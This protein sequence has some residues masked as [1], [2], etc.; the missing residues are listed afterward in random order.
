MTFQI[1]LLL[2]LSSVVLQLAAVVLI[3][4]LIPSTGNAKAWLVL[5]AAFVAMAAHLIIELLEHIGMIQGG[6]WL[7]NLGDVLTL[8]VS[9]FLVLGIWMTRK[10][11]FEYTRSKEQLCELE[12]RFYKITQS[13]QDA[14]IMMGADKKISFWNDAAERMFGYSATEALGHDMHTL[15]APAQV[16]TAFERGFD[17]F[18]ESGEGPV[19]GKV[20]EVV[21]VRKGGTEFP[22]ELSISATKVGGEWN[23]IGIVRDITER[24][25]AEDALKKNVALLSEMGKMAKVGGWEL[26]VETGELAWTEEV[27]DIHEVDMATYKPT[28]SEAV[29]FYAPASR[30]VIERL[31]DRAIKY[32]EPFDAELELITAKGNHRWV[33]A[34]GSVYQQQDKVKTVS[35]TFHDITKQREAEEKVKKSNELRNQFVTIVSHQLG[36]PLTSVR[37]NLE[38]L[39][40]GSVGKLGED[41]KNFIRTTYEAQEDALDRLRDFLAMLDI[42]EGRMFLKKEKTSF[43]GLWKSAMGEAQKKAEVKNISFTIAPF[44]DS[45]SL[46]SLDTEKIRRVLGCLADNAIKYTKE[47]GTIETKLEMRD[48]FARCTV[49]DSGVGIP[50]EEQ[51]L[52]FNCFFRATN[53]FLMF[54]DSSGLGLY[55]SKYFVEQHG[56]KIG[57]ESK[58]G[59]GST[60]WFELPIIE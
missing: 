39:L 5:S 52:I 43:E 29:G 48:G 25:R 13:A 17:R 49:K 35:G 38:A 37:W 8:V 7:G 40:K 46:L 4:R 10:M 50:V 14:I 19:V 31:V 9:I 41:Q 27:Y 23:A 28:V 26:N 12:D 51:K 44:A 36:T 47:G 34:I 57:F 18:R 55:I 45:I 3:V 2:H 56:G 1:E 59:E 16:H 53:A 60:F 32:G 22:I 20:L 15:I 24:K 11:L 21:A 58:E 6:S 54:T 33:H 42:E 30:S